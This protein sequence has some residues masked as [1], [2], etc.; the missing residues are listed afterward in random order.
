MKLE[1]L[2]INCAPSYLSFWS[3]LGLELVVKSVGTGMLF[4]SDFAQTL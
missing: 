1:F 4:A 2:L 3:S